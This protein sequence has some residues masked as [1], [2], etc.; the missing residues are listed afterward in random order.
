[1]IENNEKKEPI[2]PVLRTLEVGQKATFSLSKRSSVISCI[3]SVGVQ[4]GRRFST[5]T[6]R[7]DK[8]F[9]VERI[10]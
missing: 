6:N 5:F 1:M 9:V 7:I 4:Y 2:R 8:N 10:K 3:Y